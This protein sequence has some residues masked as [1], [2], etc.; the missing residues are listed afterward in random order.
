MLRTGKQDSVVI[1]LDAGL[2][3]RPHMEPVGCDGGGAA[4]P[5]EGLCTYLSAVVPTS[6]ACLACRFLHLKLQASLFWGINHQKLLF[7]FF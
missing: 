7:F 2:G 3:L 6:P 4:A 5:P 1:S